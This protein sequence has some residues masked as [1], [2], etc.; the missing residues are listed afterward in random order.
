MER[1]Y[2]GPPWL[3][4]LVL[5]L[6]LFFLLYFFVPLDKPEAL[7]FTAPSGIKDFE[8]EM[9]RYGKINCDYLKK[10]PATF[11]S[12]AERD[13][14]LNAT[15]YDGEKVFYQI[16]DYVPSDRLA[17]VICAGAAER[18]YRDNYVLPFNG[19]VPGFY[20]FTD[21]LTEDYLRTKDETSKKAALMLS[22]NA[23]FA[24]DGTPE[25]TGKTEYSREVSYAIL[26]YLNAERLGEPRRPRLAKLISDAIGHIDKWTAERGTPTCDIRPFMVGLTAQALIRYNEKNKDPRIVP[27][28]TKAATLLDTIWLPAEK[29]FSYQTLKTMV[30]DEGQSAAPTLNLLIAPL[31]GYLYRETRDKKYID[32]GDEVFNGGASYKYFPTGK[33]FNQHYRWSIDYLKYREAGEAGQAPAA[34]PAPARGSSCEDKLEKIRG[35]LSAG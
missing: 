35:I 24:R 20:N 10:A 1:Y 28:L 6:A 12:D 16:S 15:Y 25:D 26:S 34:T 13:P 5:A 8:S 14:Y 7:E 2:R 29:A 32:R 33:Q 9:I 18:I 23:A 17:W 19:A 27:A 3:L 21:G 30:R 4:A 11:N 22:K 31:Y